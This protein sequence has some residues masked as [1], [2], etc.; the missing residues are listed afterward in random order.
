MPAIAVLGS[1]IFVQFDEKYNA[2][3]LENLDCFSYMV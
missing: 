2:E 3:T 1:R